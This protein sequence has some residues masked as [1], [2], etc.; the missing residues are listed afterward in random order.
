MSNV[1]EK[2]SAEIGGGI[3]GEQERMKRKN[4]EENGCSVSRIGGV[5]G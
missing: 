1:I 4:E 2:Q 5:K 3:R